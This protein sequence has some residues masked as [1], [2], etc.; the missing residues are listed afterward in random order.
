M[1]LT[2]AP[3]PAERELIHT[4]EVVTRGYLRADGLWDLEGE[5]RDT[6][7]YAYRNG[8]GR[9]CPAGEPVHGMRVRLTLDESLT[10]RE[11]VA[12]MPHTPFPEC[13]G[14]RSPVQGLVGATIG[15]G[16]RKAI[17]YAM[18]DVRGCTHV[19]ELLGAMATVALQTVPNYRL[20]QRR[21]RGDPPPAQPKPG[22]Q[23]GQCL[24]WDT[25]GPVVARIAPHFVG[26]CRPHL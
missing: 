8:D 19:R 3:E 5:L 20:Y 16:W 2:P 21:Q 4:R 26:W 13:A 25:D 22:H 18:G 24:G 11:A 14:A 9:D 12:E 6:K 1:S 17:S 23:M 7:S 15:A 10:V